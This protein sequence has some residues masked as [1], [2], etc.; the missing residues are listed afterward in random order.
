[1]GP[2]YHVKYDSTPDLEKIPD[3]DYAEYVIATAKKTVKCEDSLVRQIVYTGLIADSNEPVNLGIM[4][5]TSEG[6]TYPIVETLKS[7]P[8]EDVCLIG[9]MS[10]KLLV[11]Q[12]GILVDQYNRLL[13]PQIKELKQQIEEPEDFHH[14]KGHIAD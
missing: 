2:N 14:T 1:M 6:K 11:R 13:K 7:F 8:K 5:P 4:A 12:K 9:S 10:T 3:R